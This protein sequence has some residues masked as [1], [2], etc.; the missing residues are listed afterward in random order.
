MARELGEKD[1]KNG[2]AVDRLDAEAVKHAPGQHHP[3]EAT[4]LTTVPPR[5]DEHLAAV[6]PLRGQNPHLSPGR[7]VLRPLSV[8]PGED[9]GDD[10]PPQWLSVVG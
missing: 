4:R 10:R 6:T 1:G 7:K 9:I 2:R 8:D 5:N 3:R